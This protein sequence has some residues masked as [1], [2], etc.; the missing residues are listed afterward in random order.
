MVRII[1]LL[2]LIFTISCKS[3]KKEFINSGKIGSSKFYVLKSDNEKKYPIF[4]N[5]KPSGLSF[6][7]IMELEEFIKPKIQ[8]T[9]T[10]YQYDRQYYAALSESGEKLVYVFLFC[11]ESIADF[12]DLTK[13][14]T[15]IS[16]GGDC[17]F[18]LK[19]DFS[20]KQII[21]YSVHGYG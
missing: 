12:Y 11:D 9:N 13:E 21:G 20:N 19:I 6:D 3:S 17:F 7:E 15:N 2:L 16:D 14:R 8:E 1:S 10:E 4:E 5:T 18:K